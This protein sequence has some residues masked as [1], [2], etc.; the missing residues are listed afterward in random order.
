M[1]YGVHTIEKGHPNMRYKAALTFESNNGPPKV[2][3]EELDAASPQKAA[4]TLLR[5]ARRAHPGTRWDSLCL[6]LE[7]VYDSETATGD[8]KRG[9]MVAESE[10]TDILERARKEV[11]S[12]PEWK[13]SYDVKAE[14]D[15][16]KDI[17]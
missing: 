7:K 14:L 8:P 13:L 12:L 2:H 10:T 9:L 3:R 16:L 1:Q 17:T 15:K 11:E 6:T 5:G 4:S